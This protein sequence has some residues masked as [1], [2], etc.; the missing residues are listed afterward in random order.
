MKLFI[1]WLVI[2]QVFSYKENI[3]I[4]IE[5]EIIQ[6]NIPL[7]IKCIFNN[8]E[9][10]SK[11][12]TLTWKVDSEIISKNNNIIEFHN[13]L[14][15]TVQSIKNRNLIHV[16]FISINDLKS[17]Y[18]CRY[19]NFT[20]EYKIPINKKTFVYSPMFN[21][22]N[23][24]YYLKKNII[25]INIL[26]IYPIPTKCYSKLDNYFLQNI[27]IDLNK[28]IKLDNYSYNIQ[29]NYNVDIKKICGKKLIIMCDISYL[30]SIIYIKTFEECVNKKPIQLSSLKNE[31]IFICLTFIIVLLIF[32]FFKVKFNI[33]FS[34]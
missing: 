31:I 20:K 26:K 17:T 5:P 3:T 9:E 6:L 10:F 1:I 13:E 15:Y 12:E 4:I 11:L 34:E 25:S 24:K 8:I 28:I 27:E 19:D 23:S 32:Q 33:F 14:K 22:I 30:K 7:C 21:E 29:F 16:N 2:Q 18:T